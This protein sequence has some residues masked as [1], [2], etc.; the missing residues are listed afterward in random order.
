M[1]SISCRYW[2]G[3]RHYNHEHSAVAAVVLNHSPPDERGFGEARPWREQ[4]FEA[5]T[6]SEVKALVEAWV[7]N[8]LNDVIR[9]LGLV[10]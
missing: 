5:G 4:R 2:P 3:A 8:Q 7:Q 6:E 10:T 1:L 9:L